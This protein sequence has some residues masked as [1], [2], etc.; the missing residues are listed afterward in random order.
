MV[1]EVDDGGVHIEL[2]VGLVVV[3]EV[4]VG[5]D[6]VEVLLVLDVCV[7][8]VGRLVDI[9]DVGDVGLDDGTCANRCSKAL[10]T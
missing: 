4:L 3:V 10:S 8:V 5:Y 6:E 7:E 9:L 1:L 2:E